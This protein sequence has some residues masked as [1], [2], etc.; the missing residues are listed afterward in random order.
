MLF[1]FALLVRPFYPDNPR[2]QGR[3]GSRLVS[4]YDIYRQGIAGKDTA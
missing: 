1:L 2:A 3:I 4:G